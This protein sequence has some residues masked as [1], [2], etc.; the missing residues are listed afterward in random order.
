[1]AMYADLQMMRRLVRNVQSLTDDDL[2][3]FAAVADAEI[4]AK[5]S[6]VFDLPLQQV[7]GKYPPPIPE[8]AALLGAALLESQAFSLSS[9]GATQNPYAQSLAEKADS[10]LQGIVSGAIVLPGQRR[11]GARAIAKAQDRSQ[12][13][14]RQIRQLR[15]SGST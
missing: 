15:R 3:A 6:T 1:M 8:V 7:G 2:R 5:L 10:L 9:L 13:L 4:N 11:V 12:P 14:V